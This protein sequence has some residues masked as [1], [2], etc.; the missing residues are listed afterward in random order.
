MPHQACLES[1]RKELEFLAS[2][3]SSTGRVDANLLKEQ[4]IGAGAPATVFAHA[5]DA[6]A[7]EDDMRSFLM[8]LREIKAGEEALLTLDA[9]KYLCAELW[10]INY[11]TVRLLIIRT[12]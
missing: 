8:S 6:G 9:V 12:A 11:C 4:L 5:R 7:T 1:F 3:A 2:I 10:Q